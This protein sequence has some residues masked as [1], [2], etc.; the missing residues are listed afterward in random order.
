MI[1][2]MLHKK[3]EFVIIENLNINFVN[4]TDEKLT[5]LEIHTPIESNLCS[6]NKWTTQ[7]KIRNFIKEI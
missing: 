7:K 4:K 2:Y 6:V 3:R 5:K 1:D